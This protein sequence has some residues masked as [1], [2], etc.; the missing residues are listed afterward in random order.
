MEA[1]AAQ[2][3]EDRLLREAKEATFQP[4]LSKM[5]MQ[6]KREGSGS[7]PWLRLHR[8]PISQ[9]QVH[10][11]QGT[12]KIPLWI[13]PLIPYSKSLLLSALVC[14]QW[15]MN[16]LQEPWHCFRLLFT[17]CYHILTVCREENKTCAFAYERMSIYVSSTGFPQRRPTAQNTNSSMQ[18]MQWTRGRILQLS[19]GSP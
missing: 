7:S 14:H 11:C 8:V 4:K 13:F 18:M 3:R 10:I 6:L 16:L 2:E 9:S 17:P 19:I 12:T 15:V 1:Q 5:A